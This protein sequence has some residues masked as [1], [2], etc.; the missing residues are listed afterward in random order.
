M[1]AFSICGAR[2]GG[3]ADEKSAVSF[4]ME[5]ES[6]D[7]P[8]MIFPQQMPDGSTKYF[9][10]VPDISTKDIKAMGPFPADDGTTYGVVFQLKSTPAKR[11]SAITNANKG[12]WIGARV[13]GRIV[14]GVIIDKGID[15][16]VIVIWQG[17]TLDDIN[18]LD[19][20]LPRIGQEKPKG[21]K[22]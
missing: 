19:K 16:G 10:R 4:H 7:N 20:I 13:N 11:Y 22:K 5:T 8:K 12:K 2:A 15:D 17:V 3:K 21:D 14:D 1:I 9:R 6:T 18:A